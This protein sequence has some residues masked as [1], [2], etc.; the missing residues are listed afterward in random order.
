MIV[1]KNI[2]VL[3]IGC[4]AVVNSEY[5]LKFSTNELTVLVDETKTFDLLL[6]GLVDEAVNVTFIKAHEGLADLDPSGFLINK[7][8]SKESY[9][10]EVL[11]KKAGHLKVGTEVNGEFN[12]KNK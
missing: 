5:S 8:N 12:E 4:L 11:G 1:S 9:P 7:E 3:L 10:I 6:D 2:I